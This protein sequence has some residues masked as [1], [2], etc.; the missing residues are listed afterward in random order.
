[1]SSTEFIYKHDQW[2]KGAGRMPAGLSGQSDSSV[3]AGL[4]LSLA[5]FALLYP[6]RFNIGI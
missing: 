1:M 3:Y 4:D 6:E 2:R 5:Q